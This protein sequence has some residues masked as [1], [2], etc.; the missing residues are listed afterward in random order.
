MRGNPRVVSLV[1]RLSTLLL[2]PPPV[3]IRQTPTCS[4]RVHFFH[5]SSYNF[6]HRYECDLLSPVILNTFD[7]YI[8]VCYVSMLYVL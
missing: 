5:V 3:N 7:T 2:C 8:C 6:V 4:L 1:Q